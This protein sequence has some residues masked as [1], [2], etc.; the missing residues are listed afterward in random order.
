[1]FVYNSFQ[2]LGKT[3]GFEFVYFNNTPFDLSV[4]G[5]NE[6]RIKRPQLHPLTDSVKNAKKRVEINRFK[7]LFKDD[8]YEKYWFDLPS[9]NLRYLVK[10]SISKWY[11]W[12]NDSDIGLLHLR[13]L[14]NEL[15][16]STDY[17]KRCKTLLKDLKPDIVYSTSQRSALAIAP[18]QAAKA[19]NIPTVGFVFSWDN[20]PKSML[21]VETDY[22]H[23]WSLHMKR[24]LLQYYPFVHEQQVTV[25]GTPQF[26][27]HFDKACLVS[28]SEF[29]E[30]YYL[31]I[32]KDY[33]CFSG[34]DVTTSPQ[35][36]LYL[37][38][39][40][41]AV[42]TLNKEGHSLGIIFRRCPVDFSDRYDYVLEEYKELIVPIDP[43]W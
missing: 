35:D 42:R 23:V 12:R 2:K 3:Q 25:T 28:K 19:L 26:E 14:V 21:D 40:A 10:S 4:L 1:N 20:L 41:E 24:E 37:K 9:K 11:I 36:P 29:Y 30:T 34:D 43:V 18:I 38:D 32:T 16:S 5:L 15:E 8:V 31:D 39:L 6:V 7:R 33:I 13:R 17:F 27:P 22:Y